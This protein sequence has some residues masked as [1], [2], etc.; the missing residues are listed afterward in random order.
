MS[1]GQS[2]LARRGIWCIGLIVE[3]G[4][5]ASCPVCILG[6]KVHERVY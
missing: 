5:W 2:G 6:K 4:S 1:S 3:S